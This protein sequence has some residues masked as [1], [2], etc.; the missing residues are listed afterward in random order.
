[1]TT[2]T[3]AAP[4]PEAGATPTT[5]H[6]AAPAEPVV[7][8]W[9]RPNVERYL[10][11]L[12]MPLTVVLA[13][14][15]IVLNISRMFLAT[16]GSAPVV[17]GTIITVVILIGAT[18]LSAAP[19]MRTGSLALITAGF[20]A[21]L[22]VGGWMTVGSA[23]EETEDL[24]SNLAADGPALAELD[25]ESTADLRFV[26]SEAT[27]ETGINRITMTNGGGLHT[28]VLEDPTTLFD[29]LEVAATG[30]VDTSRA[31]FG[32]PGDYVFYCS[33][34]GHREAGMEGVITAEGDP[35]TLT[36]AE[37]ELAEEGEGG[38]GGE[39]GESA[40]DDGAA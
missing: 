33:V 2:E 30:D 22:M 25:F 26:P 9:Q 8:F 4:A 1:M 14:V 18:A 29:T 16:H 5:A 23:E 39:G 13:V 40:P 11:P 3:E 24:G 35:K 32:E 34:P 27:V 15:L 7:P 21:T 17:I 6:D 10:V 19:R 31:F 12:V 20:L 37:A 38:E 36:A 28:F